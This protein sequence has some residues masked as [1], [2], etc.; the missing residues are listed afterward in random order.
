MLNYEVKLWDFSEQVKEMH[1]RLMQLMT[2][3]KTEHQRSVVRDAQEKLAKWEA[4]EAH[5][6]QKA[7]EM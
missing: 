5:E 2:K 6:I 1:S 4:K 7:F 3:A